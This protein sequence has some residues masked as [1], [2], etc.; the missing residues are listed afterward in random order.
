MPV[1]LL[2]GVYSVYDQYLMN[3]VKTHPATAVRIILHFLLIISDARLFKIN[4]VK[5]RVRSARKKN[6][7]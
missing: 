6:S 3:Y 4:L 5:Y 1:R 2:E 7:F